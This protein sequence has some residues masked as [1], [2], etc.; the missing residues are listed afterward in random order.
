[1]RS[2]LRIRNAF[3]STVLPVLQRRVVESGAKATRARR[4]DP[5]KRQTPTAPRNFCREQFRYRFRHFQEST[6]VGASNS[7]NSQVDYPRTPRNG[8]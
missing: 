5:P 2:M 6:A 1:V 3:G 4:G 8:S 7:P